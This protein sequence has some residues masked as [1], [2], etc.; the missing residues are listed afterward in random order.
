[1]TTRRKQPKDLRSRL[2]F[3]DPSHP[4]SVAIHLERYL[5]YGLTRE[6][7]QGGRPIIAIA[8]TGSDLSPCNRH[9]IELAKRVRDEFFKRSILQMTEIKGLDALLKDAVELKYAPKELTAEQVKE[10]IQTDLVK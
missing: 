1:M 4:D 6:E 8:Q 5:N 10:L 2:W 9:H 7:L 3:D